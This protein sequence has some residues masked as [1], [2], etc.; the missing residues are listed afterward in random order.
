MELESYRSDIFIVQYVLDFFRGSLFPPEATDAVTMATVIRLL[1]L[2]LQRRH[3]GAHHVGHFLLWRE[4]LIWRV[5][6]RARPGP[7]IQRTIGDDAARQTNREGAA[8]RIDLS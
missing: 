8:R 4:M 7:S 5:Y 1:N 2:R 3:R 6:E